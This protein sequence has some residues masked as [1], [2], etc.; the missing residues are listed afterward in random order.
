[1]SHLLHFGNEGR[2]L[3]ANENTPGLSDQYLDVIERSLD[4]I[5]KTGV[6]PFLM[7]GNIIG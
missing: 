5:V 2:T 4:S 1:M 7:G 3:E 6:N